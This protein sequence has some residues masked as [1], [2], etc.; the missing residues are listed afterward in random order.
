MPSWFAAFCASLR[1]GSNSAAAILS[2][3]GWSTRSCG[4][5]AHAERDPARDLA[6]DPLDAAERVEVGDA[7]ARCRRPCCRSRCRSRHRTARRSPRRRSRRRSA[8]CSRGGGRRTARRSSASP[9]SMQR[10]S[11][12]RLRSSTGPN[13]LI[14]IAAHPPLLVVVSARHRADSNRRRRALQA[15]ASPL[16][17]GVQ[18]PREE[19]NLCLRVRSPVLFL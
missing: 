10:S 18:S 3:T 16:G 6:H 14:F 9:A 7:S 5:H 19:S 4:W 17:H 15:R 13:V 11:C 12:L 1:C 8:G 2:S